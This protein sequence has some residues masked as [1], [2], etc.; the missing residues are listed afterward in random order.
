MSK[1]AR[2]FGFFSLGLGIS[3]IIGYWLKQEEI[4]SRRLA[5]PSTDPMM[6]EKEHI[7]LTPKTLD[8]APSVVD[9]L[10]RINGIGPKIAQVLSQAGITSYAQLAQASSEK[11]LP[12]LQ[13]VRGV[14][15]EK[16]TDWI[17]QAAELSH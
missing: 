10:T 1:F 11:L 13:S 5:S 15:A 17:K 4:R 14:S 7:I 3:L 6:P 16:I 12:Q 9:D 8:S 2:A